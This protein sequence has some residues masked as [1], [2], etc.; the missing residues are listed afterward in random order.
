MNNIIKLMAFIV[1]VVFITGCTTSNVEENYTGTESNLVEEK[2]TILTT[3]Y[4]VEEITKAIVLDTSNVEVLV[5]AGVEP[6]SYEPTPSQ[7]LS[8]SKADVFVTMGGMFEHLE[9]EIV[10]TN[11]NIFIIESSHDVKLIKGEEHDDHHDEHHEEEG[12]E[13]DHHE[14]E[15]HEDE[16]HE[17]EHD[18]HEGH[19]DE[20]HEEEGHEDDHHDHNHGEYDP[21]IWLLVNNMKVMTNEVLENLISLYP[22]NEEFYTNNANLYLEK[23]EKLEDEYNTKLMNCENSKAIVN[24]RAFGY[25]AEEYNF[26]QVSVAGF[27]PESEPTPK[28]IQSVIDEAKEHNLSY[29]FSEGQIDSKTAETI[30]N[31]IGGEVLELNPIKMSNDEDYFSIMKQNL[32]SLEI[33]LNCLN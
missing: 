33:G 7:I 31:D 20:H 13:E 3:F 4:P 28:T 29:V 30:A 17:E 14:D 22:Q 11:S 1:L 26:E 15:H 6:H 12:H 2:P 16:H 25:L 32:N 8:F 21:H 24:H 19:E 23:L 10:D 18:E 9:K 27:S 5:G